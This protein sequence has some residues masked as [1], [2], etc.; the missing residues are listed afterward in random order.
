LLLVLGFL[1]YTNLAEL[2]IGGAVTREIATVENGMR[3]RIFGN[4]MM[5]SIAFASIGGLLFAQLAL[6]AIANL[7][8]KDPRTIAELAQSGGA[9]FALGALSILGGVP[10]GVLFGLSHFVPLNLVS[11]FSAVGS[12]VAPALYVAF[13]GEDLSGL[14]AAVASAHFATFILTLALCLWTGVR[15]KFQY[16][17]SI[18]CALVSY[19]GWSTTSGVLHRLTN[20][21][22]R[23]VI[24]AL[25]GP[26]AVPYFAIPEGALNRAHLISG[27]LLSA[28]FPRLARSPYDAALIETCYRAVLLMT[29]LFVIGIAVLYPVLSLWLGSEF[30][31]MAHV[32]AIFL[33]FAIWTD[34][35]GRVPYALLGARS[36]MRKEANI[37]ASILVPNL[38]LLISAI[39][40]FGVT[41][42]ATVAI[43]RSFAFLLQRVRKTGVDSQIKKLI[44]ANSLAVLITI[45]AAFS[46]YEKHYNLFGGILLFSSFSISIS[47]NFRFFL[48]ALRPWRTA[49]GS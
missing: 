24:S 32:P 2:G 12:L 39:Y 41:G 48:S 6:P 18:T 20:S 16:D 15:P 21:M 27:A 4:A 23:L 33:A 8:L 30:A 29:P 34:I 42:A 35:I 5:L 3:G 25:A 28:A 44:I 36:E 31:K 22:D 14:I 37:A 11:V 19:G 7:F 43:I 46:F 49:H 10:R 17:R 13:V 38:A 45:T 47:L 26:A 40:L 9:L 1:I